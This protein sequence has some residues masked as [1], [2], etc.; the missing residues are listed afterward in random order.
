MDVFT[1]KKTD[2]PFRTNVIVV[3]V[4]VVVVVDDFF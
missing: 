4:N 3:D 1:I 2:Y